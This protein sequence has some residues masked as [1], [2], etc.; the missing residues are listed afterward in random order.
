M[1]FNGEN[2][3]FATEMDLQ[4]DT[5]LKEA[6]DNQLLIGWDQWFKG[7]LALSWK[8]VYERDLDRNIRNT[9][10]HPRLLKAEAWATKL[11]VLTWEFVREC[12]NFRNE[13]EHGTNVDP[14]TTQK[15]KL[16][17]KILWYKTKIDYFPNQY[18]QGLT[19]ESLSGLPLANLK[20]T[21]SQFQILARANK[22]EEPIETNTLDV[23]L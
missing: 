22:I 12:W 3:P 16:I 5:L 4:G 6:F 18:L 1:W 8:K 20:M 7:H 15:Q 21:D 14:V 13:E 23:H 19:E 11:I 17:R 2:F 9:P 10:N